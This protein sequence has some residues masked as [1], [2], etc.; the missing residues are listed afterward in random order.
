MYYNQYNEDIV[1]SFVHVVVP[2]GT[3]LW[4]VNLD[5]ET[6]SLTAESVEGTALTLQGIDDIHGGDGL[7]LGV[8][9]VSD[10]ITDDVL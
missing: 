7:P 9:G 8:F 5:R 2:K 1:L 10:G 6:Y 3:V 4:F